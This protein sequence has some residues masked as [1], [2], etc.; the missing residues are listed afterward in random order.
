[1]NLP[2]FLFRRPESGVLSSRLAHDLLSWAAAHSGGPIF[3]R[4][5]QKSHPVRKALRLPDLGPDSETP[6]AASSLPPT[7]EDAPNVGLFEMGGAARIRFSVVMKTR[8]NRAMNEC[9]SQGRINLTIERMVNR[10]AQMSPL[11]D[12]QETARANQPR[13]LTS[14]ARKVDM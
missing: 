12:S 6:S 14:T 1:M 11:P 7:G 13:H 5:P 4:S 10:T 3:L 9:H 2:V 8:P